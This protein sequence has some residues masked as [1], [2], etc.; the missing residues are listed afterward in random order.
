M[1]LSLKK[2]SVELTIMRTLA[3]LLTGILFGVL[4]TTAANYF[5]YPLD[6]RLP[7]L[8]GIL[9]ALGCWL[10]SRKAFEFA[11]DKMKIPTAAPAYLHNAGLRAR[12][13]AVDPATVD[14]RSASCGTCSATLTTDTQADG[15]INIT[16]TVSG[17]SKREFNNLRAR[18]E[19]ISGITWEHP[20]NLGGGTRK[21]TGTLPTGN[22]QAQALR[23][24]EELTGKRV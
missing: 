3:T 19:N 10:A 12:K 5:N 4:T 7:Y 15:S 14:D 13:A 9:G 16:V 17:L 22:A 21:L 8:V 20:T 1:M 24:L 23:K 11:E 18:A 2:S 6:A